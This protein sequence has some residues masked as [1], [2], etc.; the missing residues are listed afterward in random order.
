MHKIK[1][2]LG[3]AWLNRGRIFKESCNEALVKTGMIGGVGF[4]LGAKSFADAT[5]PLDMAATGTAIAGY[6]PTAATAG[7]TIF[8]AVFGVIIIKKVFMVVA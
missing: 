6:V 1:S 8:A 7:L 2:K 5:P 3:A 4:V